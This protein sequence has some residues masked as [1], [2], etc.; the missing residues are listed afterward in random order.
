[1]YLYRSVN[2]VHSME[3]GRKFIFS[4]KLPLMLVNG[5]AI[6]RS[7]EQR[8]QKCKNRIFRTSS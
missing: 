1:M 5:G 4:G 7:K 6:L 3:R 2:I 8:S